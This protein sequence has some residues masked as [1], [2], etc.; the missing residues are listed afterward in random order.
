MTNNREKHIGYLERCPNHVLFEPH[1]NPPS[2]WWGYIYMRLYFKH[3]LEHIKYCGKV[4]YKITMIISTYYLKTN[5]SFQRL[6][7][8]RHVILLKII[9]VQCGIVYKQRQHKRK[10][11]E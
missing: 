9:K 7:T 5:C 8:K 3:V 1:C 2:L 6:L 10:K 11:N 4:S